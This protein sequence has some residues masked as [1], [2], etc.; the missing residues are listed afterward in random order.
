MSI[1]RAGAG[2]PPRDHDD[3][4]GTV[5]QALE[6]PAAEELPSADDDLDTVPQQMPTFD[7]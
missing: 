1:D 2:S 3:D 4:L 7:D 6:F 5:P